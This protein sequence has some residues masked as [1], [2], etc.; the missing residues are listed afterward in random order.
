MSIESKIYK[1]EKTEYMFYPLIVSISIQN[2]KS[3]AQF[4]TTKWNVFLQKHTKL[5]QLFECDFRHF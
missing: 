5:C 4:L 1:I 2:F 3:I